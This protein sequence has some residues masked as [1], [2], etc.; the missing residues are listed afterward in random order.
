MLHSFEADIDD[1]SGNAS[2]VVS[3]TP[4]LS[5]YEDVALAHAR[6]VVSDLTTMNANVPTAAETATLRANGARGAVAA[7]AVGRILHVHYAV[8]LC[9]CG[10]VCVRGW[11]AQLR[12]RGASHTC[13]PAATRAMRRV[14]SHSTIASWPCVMV[15]LLGVR[16][17]VCGGGSD[18]LSLRCCSV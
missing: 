6:A 16:A 18:P 3:D 13:C 5:S 9:V 11:V 2:R 17:K 12:R 7:A 4:A 10:C 15:G 14:S 1:V 8:C